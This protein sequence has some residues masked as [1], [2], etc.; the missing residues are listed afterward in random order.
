MDLRNM[1]RSEETEQIRFMTWCNCNIENYPELKWMHHI[2][3]GGLRRYGDAKHLKAAGV[4]AGVS[5]LHLP[6]PKGRYHSLYIEMKYGSNQASKEQKEFIRDML[7]AGNLAV[8]CYSTET[9]MYITEL[10]LNL[11]MGEAVT[12]GNIKCD[13]HIDNKGVLTLL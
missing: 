4:R 2:P 11:K 3:N 5:D 10:Y 8:I 13:V 7:A 1:K 6:Y 12:A 9:A